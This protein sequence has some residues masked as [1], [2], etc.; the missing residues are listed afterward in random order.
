[1][2][3]QTQKEKILEAFRKA[4]E[5]KLSTSYLKHTLYISE[6]NGRISEL[7]KEGYIFKDCGKDEHGFTIHQLVE[8][9]SKPTFGDTGHIFAVKYNKTMY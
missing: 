2:E 3:K 8:N 5:N 6:A 7:R 4:P 9:R 1:M